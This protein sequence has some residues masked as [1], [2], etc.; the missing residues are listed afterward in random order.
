MD[1]FQYDN[2]WIGESE[3]ELL[4]SRLGDIIPGGRS[5]R[6]VKMDLYYDDENELYI[7]AYRM[8][9][10]ALGY[11]LIAKDIKVQYILNKERELCAIYSNASNRKR[12]VKF[13]VTVI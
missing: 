4:I 1:K 3:Y 7:Y 13:K 6:S 5:K 10:L 9:S 12:L 8:Y 2:F 11:T